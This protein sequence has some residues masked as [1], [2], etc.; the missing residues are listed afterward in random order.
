MDVPPTPEHREGEGARK[1]QPTYL[2]NRSEG[3]IEVSSPTHS[4]AAPTCI[5]IEGGDAAKLRYAIWDGDSYG[6]KVK[7]KPGESVPLIGPSKFANGHDAKWNALA[8]GMAR[9]R[10]SYTTTW[11]SRVT[12][13]SEWVEVPVLK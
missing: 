13:L 6:I 2:V 1:Y 4:F 9:I 7:L 12:I 3:E 10:A 11:E 5:L 8:P